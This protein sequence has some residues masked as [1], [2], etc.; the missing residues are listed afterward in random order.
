[1]GGTV[2]EV[3]QRRGSAKGYGIRV[4]RALKRVL[5]S[6]PLAFLYL[7]ILFNAPSINLSRFYAPAVYSWFF[8]SLASTAFYSYSCFF[9]RE[10][11]Y[12]RKV[13][14]GYLVQT[15]NTG[16][17]DEREKGYLIEALLSFLVLTAGIVYTLNLDWLHI[18]FI[19]LLSALSLVY[20]WKIMIPL[21]L[22]VPALEMRHILYGNRLEE[23][24]FSGSV[25]L[26]TAMVSLVVSKLRK[27]RNT[28]KKNLERLKE[29]VMEIDSGADTGIIRGDNLIPQYL[30]SAKKANE[31]IREVLSIAKHSL[32]ADSVSMFD[33]RNNLLTLRCSTDGSQDS[34]S[35]ERMLRSCVSRKVSIL[36]DATATAG[37][38]Q[39][40]HVLTPVVDG[41]MIVGVLTARKNKT[42]GEGLFA[43]QALEMF[44][45]H[46]V[47]ILRNQRVYLQMNR[48]HA[49]LKILHRGSSSLT[50]SLKTEDIARRITE[51]AHDIAPLSIA[52]FTPKSEQFELLSEIGF[53][54]EFEL[55]EKIF[56]FGNTRIGIVGSGTEPH[57]LSDL[58]V[59]MKDERIPVFPFKANDDGSVFILPLSYKKK[60]H[61]MLVLYSQKRNALSSSQIE[62][63]ELLGNQ[64][65]SSLANAKL[66]EKIEKMAITDG[67]T[68]LFNHRSFQEKL[69]EEFNRMQRFANPLSF[70]LIDIDFFKKINDAHGHPAGD[71][72]L[73]GVAGVIRETIRNVDI[74]ARYG[75]EEFAVILPGANHE[76]AQKMAERLRNTIAKQEFPF[77]GKGMRVTVSIGAA[78]SPHDTGNRDELIEKA[79]QAL[80]HAKRN[81][82]DRCVSWREIKE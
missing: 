6:S 65:S 5:I 7:G 38:R 25:V 82:R 9:R 16:P 30:S 41:N 27:E 24:V 28:Y 54:E 64:A 80:Y 34:L 2:Q 4:K 32:S 19:P 35:D 79:D 14:D 46:I 73:R 1:V 75:G 57:Y 20:G 47:K 66:H 17:R 53:R 42:S 45:R 33:L 56:D 49:G 50:T 43:I 31:D 52:L 78:T 58:K 44:S 62:L 22:A 69:S 55:T 21:S 77:E 71:E 40:V 72:V 13:G 15:L 48:E 12:L 70:L 8:L 60:L 23:E 74:P 11:R 39:A 10:K 51:A 76:G 61:G 37:G 26:I 59:E 36:F 63:L 68:G 3:L 18:L 81:G 67:L 29:E